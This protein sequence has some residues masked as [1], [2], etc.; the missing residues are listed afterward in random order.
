MH[1]GRDTE[2]GDVAQAR[3]EP[4]LGPAGARGL[5]HGAAAGG[6]VV[7]MRARIPHAHER[8]GRR[9]VDV[10]AR[11]G[12]RAG[13][14]GLGVLQECQGRVAV[15]AQHGLAQRRKGGKRRGRERELALFRLD[16]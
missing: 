11:A 3:L 12:E 16:G 8:D 7:A 2:H 13:G 1:H 6:D 4:L 14:S 15:I 9:L 5:R 10:D